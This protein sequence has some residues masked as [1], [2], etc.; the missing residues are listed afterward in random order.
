MRVARCSIKLVGGCI[1]A[2]LCVHLLAAAAYASEA[3]AE[4]RPLYDTILRWLNF[5]I[6]AFLLIKFGRQPAK[7][8]FASQASEVADGIKQVEAAKKEIDE[9][10]AA[11]RTA[12]DENQARLDQLMAAVL[13]EGERR[14]E[15]AIRDAQQHSAVMLDDVERKIE[16][17]VFEAKA[18]VKSEMIDAAVGL[19]EERLPG[20]LTEA[21]NR[22]FIDQYISSITAE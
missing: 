1:L 20:L 9:K 2:M 11:A 15:A 14:K 10:I 8:F 22:R 17:M 19:V 21:D 7:A 4:W 13:R 3:A 16:S 5:A 6:L 18:R 12:L